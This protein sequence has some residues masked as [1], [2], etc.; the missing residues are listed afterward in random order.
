[1]SRCVKD[2]NT[3]FCVTGIDGTIKYMFLFTYREEDT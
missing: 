3:E 2:T 1:M